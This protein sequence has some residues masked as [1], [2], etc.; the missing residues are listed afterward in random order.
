V[1]LRATSSGS[2]GG[3]LPHRLLYSISEHQAHNCRTK[4]WFCYRAW[5]LYSLLMT[6]HMTF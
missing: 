4:E 1:P 6:W 5:G 2:A 3:V